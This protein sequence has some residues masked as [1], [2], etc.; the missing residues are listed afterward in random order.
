MDTIDEIDYLNI[1]LLVGVWVRDD[2]FADIPVTK[3]RK[4]VYHQAEMKSVSV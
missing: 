4:T 1:L 3:I 2:V